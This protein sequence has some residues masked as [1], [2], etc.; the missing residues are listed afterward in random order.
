[1]VLKSIMAKAEKVP[2]KKKTPQD[3][4]DALVGSLFDTLYARLAKVQNTSY[5]ERLEL[6]TADT[7]IDFG[8]RKKQL[9]FDRE[10]KEADRI[11]AEFDEIFAA[12]VFTFWQYVGKVQE[13]S[14]S[15]HKDAVRHAW[16]RWAT[17][18]ERTLK[19]IQTKTEICMYNLKSYKKTYPQM[20]KLKK[21]NKITSE[22]LYKAWLNKKNPITG[23]E[24]D[25]EGKG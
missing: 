19:L 18:A 14:W 8:E 23:I 25:V 11:L 16:T 2:V 3:V 24:I 12:H 7:T 5:V 17:K 1:M 15:S 13:A 6:L 20:A 9:E 10:A 4:V 21:L 22:Q